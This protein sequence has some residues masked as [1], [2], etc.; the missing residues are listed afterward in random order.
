M[1]PIEDLIGQK[2][3]Y[4]KNMRDVDIEVIKE[5]ACEDADITWQLYK[6]LK[7]EIACQ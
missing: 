7:K 4:Q 6:L 1:V 2:G 3:I 5:Y